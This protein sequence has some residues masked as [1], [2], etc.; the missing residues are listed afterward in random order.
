[1]QSSTAEN[2][3]FSRQAVSVEFSVDDRTDKNYGF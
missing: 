3:D 2:L 1:M